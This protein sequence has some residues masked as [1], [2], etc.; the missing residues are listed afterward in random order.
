[1][2]NN[3]IRLFLVASDNR[4]LIAGIFATSMGLILFVVWLAS[5]ATSY[6]NSLFSSYYLIAFCASAVGAVGWFYPEIIRKMG[7]S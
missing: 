1:M 7:G 3:L 5:V 4:S 6:T 2:L